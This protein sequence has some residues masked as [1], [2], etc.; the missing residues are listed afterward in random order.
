MRGLALVVL[1]VLGLE[2]AGCASNATSSIA[3]APACGPS[4][5]QFCGAFKAFAVTDTAAPHGIVYNPSG[6]LQGLWYDNA[7]T[8]V[9]SG[10]LQFLLPAGENKAYKTPTSGAMPASIN[11]ASDFSIWFTETVANKVATINASRTIVEFAVPTPNSQPLDITR[12]PDGVMWFT[13]SAAGKIGRIASDGTVT[14]FVIGNAAS[15]PTAVITGADGALWFTEVGAG[16]IGRLTTQGSLTTFDAGPGHM[17]GDITDGTD[18]AV[19]FNKD[20]SVTR[21]TTAG[22]RTEFA[23]PSGIFE[24]GAIFGSRNGGVYL[25]A[26]KTNGVGAIVSVSPTGATQEFDLPQNNLL[27]I[28]MAQTADGSFWMTV[29]SI[30]AG[31]SP[32][33]IFE[34]Q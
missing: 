34:L 20:S 21:M 10:V 4:T 7:T 19:L 1:S 5:G 2:L 23:L 27:P 28:E 31:V 12:G 22:V 17:S 32:S 13:E 24:T 11:I 3:P 26:I 14:E 16:V 33:V 30:K 6:A 29:S 18:G 8:D 25:G 9:S 15:Q